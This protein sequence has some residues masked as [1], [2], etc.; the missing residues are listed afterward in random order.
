MYKKYYVFIV[1]CILIGLT[2]IFLYS[3]EQTQVKKIKWK[4]LSAV[5]RNTSIYQNGMEKF[6]EDVKIISDGLFEIEYFAAPEYKEIDRYDVFDAV[7]RGTVEM[8]F[9]N[10]TFWKEK[11]ELPGSEFMYAVP[12]GLSAKD[13]YAWLYRG[14][15]LELWR[16][17]FEPFN[18]IPFPIGNTGGA[19]GGWFRSEIKRDFN[20]SGVKIRA[21]GLT[22]KVYKKLEA[23]IPEKS[24]KA[25]DALAAYNNG[26]LDAIVG[27]GPFSDQGFH[28]Y[29]GT[30]Y[31]YYP[32]WQE[33]GGVI[34]LIINKKLFER[35]PLKFQKTIEIACGNTYQYISNQF[36]SMNSKALRELVEKEGV[37]LKKIPPEVLDKFR[38]KSKEVLDEEAMKSPQFAKIYRAFKKFKEDNVNSGWSKIVDETV[39]S[40]PASSNISETTVS[41]FIER[42]SDSELAKARQIGKN[43][44]FISFSGDGLFAS[45]AFQPTPAFSDEIAHIAKIILDNSFSIKSIIVEGHAATD[46]FENKNLEV[47]KKRADAVAEIL[48]ANGIDK[49]LIKVIAYGENYPIIT[50]D[51]TEQKR[52]I[53]RRVEIVIE[54]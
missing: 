47:S 15:G 20:F 40:E 13:M 42:L 4:V 21:V 3:Q 37:L 32:G 52:R 45:W 29:Q 48:T 38:E 30:K 12:F 26:N 54:F 34:S 35:L 2:G 36:D 19:M 9:G 51:D 27:L 14:S 50:P 5:A 25:A 23:I 11:N 10:S 1:F 24:M 8:G 28:F 6:A 33:P 17:M 16:E 44:V 46:G 41:K 31:Y 18:V 49:S 22:A 7:S 43:N 53:N 39:Y